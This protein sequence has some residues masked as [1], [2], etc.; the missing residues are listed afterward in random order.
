MSL[1]QSCPPGQILNVTLNKCED[2]PVGT[3]APGDVFMVDSWLSLPSGFYSDVLSNGNP[4]F[5]KE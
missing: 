3:E 1:V 2:C 4:S 5:C